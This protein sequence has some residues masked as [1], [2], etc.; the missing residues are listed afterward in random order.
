MK[1]EPLNAERTKREYHEK[2]RKHP[3]IPVSWKE[4]FTLTPSVV[5]VTNIRYESVKY[6]PL[7]TSKKSYK[8]FP[9]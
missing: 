4:M 6:L 1:D 7:C 5:S 8:T 9:P 2:Y 3:K